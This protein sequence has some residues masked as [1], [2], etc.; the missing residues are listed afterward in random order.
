MLSC[1]LGRSG[2]NQASDF[3]RDAGMR[4]KI[5][6]VIGCR[7]VIGR[8][9]MSAGLI[10]LMLIGSALGQSD[11]AST[12]RQIRVAAAQIPVTRDVA[13]NAAAIHRA[14]DVAIREKAD[15]LLTPEG[16][17][18]G[19]TPDF[20]QALVEKYLAS[21]LQRAQAAG[22]AL[23]LGTCFVEADDNKCY[24][25]IRFYDAKGTLLGFH[26]KTL[27]C[28]TLT[29]PP[30]GEINSYAT[31][32]L[33]TFELDGIR[34]GGLI[35]NDMWGNPQCTPVPDPHL[36]QK[37]SDA[38]AEV[39]FLAINGGRN[40][41]QWSRNVYWHYHETNMRMRAAAGKVWVVSA[42]NCSPQDIPCSAPTGVIRP[43][44]N[45]AAK[46]EQQGEQVVV[47]TIQLD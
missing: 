23:A 28:G 46:A 34:I 24:N 15:I 25:Q 37:L 35:C 31:R 2:P 38:G 44:G 3:L 29:D 13:A 12:S 8:R 11:G 43:D 42:D 47:H 1:A 39:I 40:G 30:E 36:S 14:L 33:R 7:M 17:L 20:D 4:C 45:W 5:G 10:T 6:T 19:Y 27:L 21:I 32:P 18:S 26:T 16:S 41:G 9:M 22:M